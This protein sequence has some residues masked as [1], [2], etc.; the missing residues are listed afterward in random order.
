MRPGGQLPAGTVLRIAE[1]AN[2]W[3]LLREI[4]QR[5]GPSTDGAVERDMLGAEAR[6]HDAIKDLG[7]QEPQE[8]QG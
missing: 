7:G 5:F 4:W 3:L 2:G 8:E 1:A 6:L